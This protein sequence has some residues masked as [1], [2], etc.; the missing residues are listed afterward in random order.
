MRRKNENCPECGG[1]HKIIDEEIG[2][3]IC[4]ECGLVLVEGIK[5]KF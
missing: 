3:L 2:E 4:I 5:I 1:Q